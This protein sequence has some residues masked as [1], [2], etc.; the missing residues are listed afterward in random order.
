[1]LSIPLNMNYFQNFINYKTLFALFND[2][3]IMKFDLLFIK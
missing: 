3:K 1:M 2:I